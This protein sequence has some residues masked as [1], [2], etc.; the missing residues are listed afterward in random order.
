MKLE[1]EGDWKEHQG[2][3][4]GCSDCADV[5]YECFRGEVIAPYYPAIAKQHTEEVL[6]VKNEV[7]DLKIE[8][9][10]KHIT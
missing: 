10:S 2:G 5:N 3:C 6:L 8:D 7:S 4:M 9:F 1:E